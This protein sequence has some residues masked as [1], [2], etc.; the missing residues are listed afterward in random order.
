MIAEI[1]VWR[2]AEQLIKWK[3]AEAGTHASERAKELLVSGDR[4]GYEIWLQIG[5]AIAQLLTSEPDGPLH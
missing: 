4:D 3:G 2:A 1:D 5:E